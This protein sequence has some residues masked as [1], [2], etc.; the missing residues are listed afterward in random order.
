MNRKR[1]YLWLLVLGMFFLPVALQAAQVGEVMPSFSLTTLDGKVIE[2]S[3]LIGNNPTF[4]VF[5]ATWCPNC[6]AEIP[7]INEMAEEFGP[8]GMVFLGVNVGVNDSL[9]KVNRYAEKYNIRYPL[10]FDEGSTLTRKFKVAG[11][12]TVIIVDKSGIIRYR[13][14]APPPDLLTHFDALNQ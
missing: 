8:K 13:G 10:Y 12:P 1:K 14:V 5:W 9:K 11:T 6:E 7:H 3:D 2:S 4:L